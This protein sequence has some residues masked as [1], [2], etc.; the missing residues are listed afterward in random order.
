MKYACIERRRKRYPVRMMCRLLEVSRSGYYAWRMRPE[1]P[2][3]QQDR[4]LLSQIRQVHGKSKGV[5]GSP[6]VHAELA[7]G[8]VRVGRHRVAR[9]MRL[10]RLR[11]LCS[12]RAPA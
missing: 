12:Y 11:R 2:R 1:S 9:L 8:G 3:A 5:Y 4:E 6:R 10:A 7:A